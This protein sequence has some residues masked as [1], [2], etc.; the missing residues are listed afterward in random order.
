MTTELN[1]TKFNSRKKREE[2]LKNLMRPWLEQELK[3][4]R[5]VMAKLNEKWNQIK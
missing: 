2:K 5:I 3:P 1:S 4:I